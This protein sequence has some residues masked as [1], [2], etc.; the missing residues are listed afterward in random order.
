MKTLILSLF[1]ILPHCSFGQTLFG[2][3]GGTLVD[4]ENKFSFSIG[5]PIVSEISGTGLSFNIGFQQPYGDIFTS[6]AYPEVDAYQIYPNPFSNVFHF[7]AKSEI[8]N[9]CLFDANGREVYRSLITGTDFEYKVSNLPK[10]LYQL[11]V[12][13]LNGKSINSKVIHQ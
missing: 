9:F 6:N 1:L 10:G 2:T 5:E 4:M 12:Q 13:L 8:E 7:E 11:R 3:A